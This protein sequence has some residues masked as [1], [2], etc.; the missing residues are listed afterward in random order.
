MSSNEAAKTK[1]IKMTNAIDGLTEIAFT[2]TANGQEV[3]YTMLARDF[4]TLVK[5][6]DHDGNLNIGCQPLFDE[7]G[8]VVDFTP[9]QFADLPVAK[10]LELAV[11]AEENRNASIIVWKAINE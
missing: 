2:E 7:D 11:T 1:G 9:D 8:N 3:A 10:Q 4:I 5:N 6:K